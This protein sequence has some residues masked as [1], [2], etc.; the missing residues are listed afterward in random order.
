MIAVAGEGL[1]PLCTIC[2]PNIAV[3]AGGSD[4]HSMQFGSLLGFADEQLLTIRNESDVELEITGYDFSNDSQGGTFTISGLGAVT[5]PAWGTA[6]AAISYLCDT[7]CV[8]LPVS[9]SD[10]NILHIYSNDPSEGDYA[11]ELSG[12]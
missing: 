6:S 11:I 5:L 2:D 1:E 9:F 7:F 8:D 10:E 4:D 3:E 12:V